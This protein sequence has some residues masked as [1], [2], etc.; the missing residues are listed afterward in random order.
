MLYALVKKFV[1]GY[2]CSYLRGIHRCYLC[3]IALSLTLC[4]FLYSDNVYAKL[5][6]DWFSS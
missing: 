1:F 6:D 3:G 2:I 5:R 4:P